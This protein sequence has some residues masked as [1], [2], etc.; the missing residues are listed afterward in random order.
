MFLRLFLVPALIVGGLV[1]VLLVL[2]P[3]FS[4]VRELLTGKRDTDSRTAEQFL[5]SLDDDNKTV[6]WQAASD[7]SQVLLRDGRLAG[8]ADFAL[9]L[10]DRL[11][12]ARIATAPAE[13]D[14]AS[15][16]AT[17]SP[18]EAAQ[19]RSKLEPDRN[20]ILYLGACL[21]NF[22]VPVGAPVLC[23]LAKQ[24]KG[25]EPKALAERRRQA[26][27]AL[28]NLGE[29]IKRFDKLSGQG[30]Q[31]ILDQLEA[32]E[33]G[34]FGSRARL[35]AE[36]LRRRQDGKFS[37]LGVDKALI[38]CSEADDPSLR[39]MAA[40]AMNFWHGTAS[41]DAAMEKALVRLSNDNGRGEGELSRLLEENS[42]P[43]RVVI[44]RAGFRVQANATVAL[45]RRGSPQVRLNLLVEMLDPEALR[46]LFVVQDRKSGREQP[47]E[48]LVASTLINALKATAE[49]H[50]L[51]PEMD[52][53]QLQPKVETLT[54]DANKAIQTEALQTQLELAKKQEGNH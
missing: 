21:G 43:T 50:R 41:E 4:W 7:L 31:I 44:K 14:F 1:G 47:E 37:A 46:Q 8:D 22:L 24:E 3:A 29:N 33:K 10:A 49:L 32:A 30:Q 38:A 17:L 6:R 39:E 27:W 25:M 15:R 34:P 45:A 2:P 26:V 40:F 5:Q 51:R 28:A 18:A 20:Y 11:D 13:D 52:L 53:P 9:Q 23:E 48:E 35:A 12:R 19:E 36:Y 42:S 16:A 54:R